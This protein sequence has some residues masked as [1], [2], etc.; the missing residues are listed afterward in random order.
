MV[1]DTQQWIWRITGARPLSN[2]VD[3]ALRTEPEAVVLSAIS[4][5][6][7]LLLLNKGRIRSAT[8]PERTVRLWLQVYPLRIEPVSTEVAILSRTLAFQHDDPADRFIASTAYM[9][10]TPLA[11]SDERLRALSWLKTI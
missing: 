8:D 7:A 4:I 6:E 1:L 5:W 10:D 3:Q 11:T 9:L 2:P